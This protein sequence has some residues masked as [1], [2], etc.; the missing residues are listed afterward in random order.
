[1]GLFSKDC[2][3]CGKDVGTLSGEK[4]QDGKVCKDCIEKLSPWFSDFKN[5]TAEDLQAQIDARVENH[6]LLDEF[7]MTKAW[8]VK[9]YPLSIQFIYDKN[10]RWFVCVEGP[11]ETFK[12]RLPD[13]IAFDQVRDV[14]LDV[15]ERWAEEYGQ[16]AVAT[17]NILSQDQYD[18]VFWHYDFYL[19]ILLDHPY[20]SHIRYKMNWNS[21]IIKVPNRNFMFRRGLELSGEYRGEK[22]AETASR[23]EAMAG[24]EED[25]IDLN[26]KLD[27]ITLANKDKSTGEAVVGGLIKDAK[28]DYY[29]TRIENVANH[30]K[31]VEKIRKLL[32]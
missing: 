6:S 17:N 5:A 2:L 4:I 16:Y 12:D 8:G 18:K 32:L 31:R 24:K 25:R 22:I 23:I 26:K 3:L 27:V 21:T 20:L 11:A 9:K 28:D 7:N 13:V 29:I 10:H 1:M 30:I 19:N 15:K 14:Y